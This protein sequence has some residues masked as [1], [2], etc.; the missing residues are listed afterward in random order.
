VLT[1]TPTE[2]ELQLESMFEMPKPGIGDPVTFYPK[3]NTS[4]ANATIAFVT[5]VG[6]KCIRVTSLGHVGYE[7]VRHV[8]DPA[9]KRSRE[10]R[11]SGLWD[12]PAAQ[13]KMLAEIDEVRIR[14]EQLEERVNELL[15]SVPKKGTA[16]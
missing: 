3:G 2:Q 15:A 16:K 12:F 13:R 14:C 7:G 5:E 4:S 8:D 1:E 6:N 11:E 9:A 10:I